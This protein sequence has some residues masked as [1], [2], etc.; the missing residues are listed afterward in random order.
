MKKGTAKVD[1][2]V[3][4]EQITQAT[5]DIIAHQGVKGLT[6]SAIAKKVGV[7]EG[8]L[9]R[10]FKNK[11]E[12]L[13]QAI[14]NVGAGLHENL[15]RIQ[16]A[17]SDE[18]LL[19]L[20]NLFRLHLYYIEKNG[21]IPRLVFSEEIHLGNH[22]FR[23]I[24]LNAI[25]SYVTGVE[26]FIREGQTNGSIH[27]DA[28]ASALALIFIGMIQMSTLKWSLNGFSFSLVDEGMRLW[29]NFEKCIGSP[30]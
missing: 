18:P 14:E 19:K 17:T 27:R 23:K 29:D 25:N 3:R 28:D 5:F 6:V 20:R 24:L 30:Q 12:I 16:D 7:S 21:G 10:H 11:D 15:K 8:N 22:E 13:R 2:E 4:R 1:T 26:S 9:Y